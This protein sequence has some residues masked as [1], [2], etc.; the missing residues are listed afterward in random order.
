[1]SFSGLSTAIDLLETTLKGNT[2]YVAID[3]R[4]VTHVYDAASLR[5]V[6]TAF[7]NRNAEM[8]WTTDLAL[9]AKMRDREL[10]A[11]RAWWLK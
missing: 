3:N 10:L 8:R 2:E 7:Q 4:P 1:M 11:L 9:E 5:H 6:S